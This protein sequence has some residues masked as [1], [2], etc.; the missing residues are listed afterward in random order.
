MGRLRAEPDGPFPAS[1]TA[2]RLAMYPPFLALLIL[3]G[4]PLGLVVFAFACFTNHPQPYVF[5]ARLQQHDP[6]VSGRLRLV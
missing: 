3:K 6:L 1:I 2:Y 4:A 5:R